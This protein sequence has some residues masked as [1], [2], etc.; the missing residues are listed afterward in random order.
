MDYVNIVVN[1]NE[2][3]NHI[4]I[5][6]NA[7]SS[8]LAPFKPNNENIEIDENNTNIND[9]SGESKAKPINTIRRRFFNI[10]SLIE[11]SHFSEVKSK[12]HMKIIQNYWLLH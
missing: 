12:S 11:L 9:N 1:C 5:D 6:N 2:N 4:A 8:N 3:S 10:R 7:Q